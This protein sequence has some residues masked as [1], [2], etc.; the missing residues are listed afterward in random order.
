MGKPFS[1]TF[2]SIETPLNN[3]R[4]HYCRWSVVLLA[5]VSQFYFPSWWHSTQPDLSYSHA[6]VL[7]NVRYS[8][9]PDHHL[10]DLESKEGLEI[11]RGT[12]VGIS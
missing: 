7:G 9:Y 3:N 4:W 10:V 6:T 12:L 2:S 11:I 5:L 8:L 1:A